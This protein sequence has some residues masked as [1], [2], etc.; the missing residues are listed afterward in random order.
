MSD[1]SKAVFLSYASQDAEAA[2]RLCSGLRAAGVAVWFDQSELVGGDAW[3]AKIR[4]QIKECAL[5]MPIISANTQAR[6]EGYFRI[7]WKLAAQR[8]HA[9]AARKA[10]L[11]PIVIDDTRDSEAHVPEEFL[12]VQWTRLPPAMRDYGGQA[13]DDAG[14]AAFCARVATVVA[15]SSDLETAR[16][17]PGGRDEDRTAPAPVASTAKQRAWPVGIAAAVVALAALVAVVI[18]SPWKRVGSTTGAVTPATSEAAR[19]VAKAWEQMDK[20]DMARSEL[21]LAEGYCRQAAALEEANAT[22]WA[23]WSAMNTWY[24]FHQFE[25]VPARKEAARD[26]AQK[27]L[28]LDPKSYEAR[29]AWAHF[30]VRMAMKTG[31]ER[32]ALPIL[33][34]LLRERPDEPRALY[35]LGFGLICDPVTVDEGFATLERLAAKHPWFAGRALNELGWMALFWGRFGLAESAAERAL[36]AQPYWNNLGLKTTL[37]LRLHGDL[38]LAQ[39]TIDRLPPTVLHENWGISLAVMVADWRGDHARAVGILESVSRDWLENF[40]YLGPTSFLSGQM[41]LKAKQVTA[42]EKDFRRAL[43]LIAV[44]LVKEPNDIALLSYKAGALHLLGMREEADKTYRQLREVWP[45]TMMQLYFEPPEQALNYV[46]Q[47]LA[48]NFTINDIFPAV[49]SFTAASLRLDPIFENARRAPDF[50]ALVEA[51]QERERQMRAAAPTPQPPAKTGATAPDK[52]LATAKSVAVLPFRNVGGDPAN[53]A[54]VEGIG[55]E[56]ISVLGRV[57]G[58]TVRGNSSLSYFNGSSASAEEKGRRLDVAYLVDGSIQRSGDTLR[59]AANLTRAATNEIAWTSAPL[60]RDVKNLFAVQEEIAALIAQNLS[61]KLGASS[62]ASIAA[63][64]P[65]AL[66]LYVQARQAWNLRT[67]AG[68]DRAEQLLQ[69]ALGLEPSFARAHA[70]LA[71]V[72]LLRGQTFRQVGVFGTRDS[73][74][75]QQVIAKIRYAL[76]LDRDSAEAHAS[77]GTALWTGW[78]FVGGERALRRAL[79]LNPNYASAHQ[80]LGRVLLSLGRMDEALVELKTASQLDPLSSRIA[81]NLGLGLGCAGRLTESLAAYDQALAIQPGALQPLTQKPWVLRRLGRESEARAILLGVPDRNF[82]LLANRIEV[83]AAGG[84]RQEAAA[85]FA[86]L[87]AKTTDVAFL[88]A[89]LGRPDDA[90]AALDAANAISVMVERWLFEPAIDPL[91]NDPR[92]TKFLATL[93]LTEAHARAQ[94]WRA[95]H[96]AEKPRVNQ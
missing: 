21:L 88:L 2:L 60:N 70:A 5:F 6:L 38:E 58:L 73:S 66:E 8:T 86:G 27:A 24:Y 7:E 74:V 77:L 69:R 93:G 1:A 56:L 89:Q 54:I 72:G 71:D 83:L 53:E 81:D 92:F 95:A 28:A 63:V 12:S 44:R 85:L 45:E 11:L 29:Y 91:R 31:E 20:T 48:R 67:T 39:A 36:K 33:R 40:F 41:R 64:K 13:R 47:M 25:R 14:V 55:F 19:L 26:Y 52:S 94:A 22:V 32:P 82:L 50:P 76:E 4:K 15:S 23:A 87:D 78:D 90:L 30:V 18:W 16:V 65:E 57:P 61:L 9:M 51:Q 62:A 10:F 79:E 68:F 43:E 42:A 75:Q 84:L 35:A 37:A 96:P 3:D 17:Q 59:I 46:R 34:E 80:W 49:W